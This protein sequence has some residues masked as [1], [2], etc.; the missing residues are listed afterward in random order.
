MQVERNLADILETIPHP[1]SSQLPLHGKRVIILVG[2][3]YEDLELHYPRLRLI[4]TGAEV[5]VAGPEGQMVYEG[6]MGYPQ[7]S[8]LGVRDLHVEDADA[9]VIPGGWMPDRLRRDEAVLNFVRRMAEANKL[10]A[11]VCHGPSID[12]S[13]KIVR[14]VKYTSSPGIK[15]DLVNAGAR[16]IDKDCVV[17]LQHKRI[18][19]RAVNDLP[20]FT[21]AIIGLMLGAYTV[22]PKLVEA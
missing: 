22:K 20:A 21:R 7:V 2:P 16:W 6:K 12:I 14:G 9:L 13:A 1:M 5:I 4:E 8:D 19:A 15:D 3:Q 17:D 18:S 11:S 10:I